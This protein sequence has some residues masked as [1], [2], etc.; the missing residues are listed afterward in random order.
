MVSTMRDTFREME[1]ERDEAQETVADATAALQGYL[2]ESGHTS[3]PVTLP[4][5]ALR[6]LCETLGLL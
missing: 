1:R 6:V 2:S 3:A 5:G 4:P